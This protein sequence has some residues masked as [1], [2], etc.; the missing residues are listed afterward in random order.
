MRFSPVSFRP[1]FGRILSIAMAVIAA[2]GVAGF[3]V[4]G[5]WGGLA[6]Y[7]WGLLLLVAVTFTLFW[8]PHLDVD[9]DQ[10]TV[11]NVFS[12]VRVPWLAIQRIDT[13]FALTLYT[14]VGKV[15]A[16]ASPA[17]SRYTAQLSNKADVRASATDGTTSIRPGDLLTTASGAAAFVIRRHWEELRDDGLLETPPG[18]NPIRDLGALHRDIHWVTIT[19]LGALLLATALGILL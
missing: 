18:G 15:T 12:T 11:G 5:D 6:R 4:T 17:P 19:V 2:L 10:V 9:V 14:P 7:S 13:K 1:T 8:F 3:V 16:W